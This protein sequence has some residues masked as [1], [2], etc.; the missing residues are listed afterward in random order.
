VKDQVPARTH[1]PAS[2][3]KRWPFPLRGSSD[4]NGRFR[5]SESR[6]RK[7]RGSG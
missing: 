5:T 3:E 1:R 2:G 4:G 6:L 7:S